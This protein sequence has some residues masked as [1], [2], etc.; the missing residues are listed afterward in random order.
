MMS[1]VSVLMQKGKFEACAL[2]RLKIHKRI[3]IIQDLELI[4]VVLCREFG[5]IIF[6]VLRSEVFS[7]RE[8]IEYLFGQKEYSMRQRGWLGIRD[9]L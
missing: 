3:C 6:M 8:N 2:R 1:L 9:E 7:N 4:A 5:C